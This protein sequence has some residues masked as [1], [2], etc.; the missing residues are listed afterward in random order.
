MRSTHEEGKLSQKPQLR[1]RRRGV[2]YRI[3][4]LA[5]QTKASL[6]VRENVESSHGSPSP[7]RQSPGNQKIENLVGH[8]LGGL[9]RLG[10][11]ACEDCLEYILVVLVFV[12]NSFPVRVLCVGLS[13]AAIQVL[14]TF[15]HE[16]MNDVS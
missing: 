3:S 11:L 16:S 7:C 5:S 4:Q 6:R 14:R 13:C 10:Q 15:D 12:D 1:Q 2:R 8:P 9:F